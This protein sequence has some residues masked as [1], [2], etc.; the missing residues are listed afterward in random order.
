MLGPAAPRSTY[1]HVPFC[2][3][4]CGYCNFTLLAGRDDL[5]AA[6]LEALAKELSWLQEPQEVDTLFFGGG[7]PTHLP[8]AELRELLDLAKRWFPLAPGYELSVEANPIDL[9]DAHCDVLRQGGVTRISLGVQSFRGEKLQD[10]ERDHR[11][12]EILTAYENARGLAQSVS[13][14]LIFAAPGETL[15]QWR[16]DLE[17]AISLGPDHVSTYGLTFE[18]GTSFWGRLIRG[19]LSRAEEETEGQMY[20]LAIDLLAAA[21][22]EHYEISNFARP[23]HRCRH[24]E[25]Y[26]TGRPYFAS[27]P[28]AARFIAGRREMNHRSTTT[29]IQRVLSGQSPVAE[30]EE[31]APG[32]HAR[33]RLVFALRRLEGISLQE[34]EQETGYS[35]DQLVDVP[36]GKFVAQGLFTRTNNNLRLTRRGLLVSDALWPAFLTPDP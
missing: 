5:M 23:G 29:Y 8:P 13:L 18:R 6:Y 4:R 7:T 32:D 33:E 26:W 10:L 30:S 17:A 15:D 9:D 22:Y 34:F 20:E 11:Q 12:P 21:G 16:R 27:G 14:D 3:H 35:V 28:G 24:N 31:L 25:A 19:Q 1:I 2:R 36:L